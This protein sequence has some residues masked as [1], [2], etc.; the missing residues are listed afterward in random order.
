MTALLSLGFSQSAS[1]GRHL[2]RPHDPQKAQMKAPQIRAHINDHRA[3][4][5]DSPNIHCSEET[6]W[7]MP[8]WSNR[9]KD[10]LLR[11]N[12]KKRIVWAKKHKDWTLDS[13]NCTLVWWV[14][15]SDVWFQPPCLCE[16]QR[17][18]ADGF[19]M[20]GSH[21]EA[22]RRK[23]DGVGGLCWWHCWKCIQNS[24]HT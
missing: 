22:W 9:C 4:G 14:H 16:T 23:C 3:Q 1:W 11:M 8:S 24:R 18:W 10:P 15:I 13:V 20:C 6:A 2:E 17:R 12:K 21:R 5:A 7:I 19:C